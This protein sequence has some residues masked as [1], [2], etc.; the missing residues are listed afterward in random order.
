MALLYSQAST[1][2]KAT[3]FLL[4]SEDLQDESSFFRMDFFGAFFSE[5]LVQSLRAAAGWQN[6]SFESSS[7]GS[8]NCMTEVV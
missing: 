5:W 7:S 6:N 4:E 3:E 2:W 8:G 1:K